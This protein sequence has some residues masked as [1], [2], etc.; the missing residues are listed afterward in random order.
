MMTAVYLFHFRK[1]E[2]LL[3]FLANR[4]FLVFDV[5]DMLYTE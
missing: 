1:C 2:Y 5:L 3:I 4:I